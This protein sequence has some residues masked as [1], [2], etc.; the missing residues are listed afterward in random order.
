MVYSSG[1]GTEIGGAVREVSI[2]EVIR[3]GGRARELERGSGI[4]SAQSRDGVCC[5]GEAGKEGAVL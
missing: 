5:L 2:I 3:R 4:L 1:T